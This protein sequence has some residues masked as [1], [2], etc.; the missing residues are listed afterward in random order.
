[1]NTRGKLYLHR[2][3]LCVKPDMN[4]QSKSSTPQQGFE[5]NDGEK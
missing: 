3:N 4:W 1:M 2:H 5:P